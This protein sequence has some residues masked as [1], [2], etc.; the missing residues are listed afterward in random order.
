MVH[1]AIVEDDPLFA[2]QLQ[3]YIRLYGKERREM[4]Q[5]TVFQ[6]GEDIVEDYRGEYDVILMDIQ[7]QF[8][9]GMKAAEIIRE[10]D[11][12]VELFFITNMPQHAIRGYEVGARYYIVKPVE[13]FS[14]SQKL[15]LALEKKRKKEQAFIAVLS[16]NGVYKLDVAEILYVES[17]GHKVVFHMAQR[18][19]ATR[20]NL[21]DIESELGKYGFFRC[22]K[23]YLVNM[24]Q[25]DAVTG[26]NCVIR[27][28]KIAISRTKKK[29]FMNLLV[30]YIEKV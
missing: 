15:D 9:N 10:R 4:I 8:M 3:S 27:D 20:A 14:F 2:E 25:V 26:G 6:D 19:L 13:Y 28:R 21:K 11:R 22:S 29:E 24:C 18:E 17:M 7:M 30:K 12:D 23:S 1:I 16:D 5:T